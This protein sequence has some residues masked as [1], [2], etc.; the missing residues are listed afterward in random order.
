[1]EEA[2]RIMKA[3]ELLEIERVKQR[4]EQEEEQE[5]LRI[6]EDELDEAKARGEI[7]D[8]DEDQ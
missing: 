3:N 5:E 7:P 6:A 1:M 8:S 2:M 4:E